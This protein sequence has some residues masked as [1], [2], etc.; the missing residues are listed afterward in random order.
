[1]RCSTTPASSTATRLERHEGLEAHSFARGSIPPVHQRKF[2]PAHSA[3]LYA[4]VAR[5]TRSLRDY[6]TAAAHDLFTSELF[7]L[8][9][10]TTATTG[11][12]LTATPSL[13]REEREMVCMT[14]SAAAQ[15]APPRIA[16]SRQP[17]PQKF[18]A[19]GRA[20]GRRSGSCLRERAV[21]ERRCG[22]RALTPLW[23][24]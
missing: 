6:G 20:G 21:H 13:G 12:R 11:R 14:S 16:G 7:P 23:P 17:R 10:P 4:L 19:A 22:A 8:G 9:A 3:R 5:G 2:L 18:R 15:A 1:M 24:P